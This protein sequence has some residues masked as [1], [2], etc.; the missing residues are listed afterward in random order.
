MKTVLIVD[1]GNTSTTLALAAGEKILHEEHC[2]GGVCR[3]TE[4]ISLIRKITGRRRL[5]GSI[6][7]SVVPSNDSVWVHAMKKTVGQEPLMVNHKLNMGVSIDYPN[8][9]RI[10]AD[11]LANACGA[12]GRYG[13]PVIVADFGTALTFDVVSSES[14]Y[15]GGVIVPGLPFMTDYLAERTELL[16]HIELKGR[17]GAVGKSTVTAMRLGAKIGY[18]GMVRE[19]VNHVKA[20]LG[21]KRIKLC[22]TGGYASWALKGLDIPFVVDMNLTVY[23]LARMYQ[24][25]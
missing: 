7:C 16:P 14:A 24:L 17:F 6:L 23:G 18:Q 10:G 22:A 3:K 19:I 11:R 1:I 21:Y 12:V 4:V 20:G 5:D 13:A 25:N 15:I 2:H 9:S 8:P